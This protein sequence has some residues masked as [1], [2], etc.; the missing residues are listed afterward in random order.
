MSQTK[1]HSMYEWDKFEIIILRFVSRSC[2]CIFYFLLLSE[3]SSKE[4]L[5]PQQSN[6]RFTTTGWVRTVIQSPWKQHENEEWI[7]C[8]SL[9]CQRLFGV[10]KLC[11]KS[12]RKNWDWNCHCRPIECAQLHPVRSPLWFTRLLHMWM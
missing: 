12:G 3:Y 6:Q 11:Q 9:H 2:Q 10:A 5:N 1:E 7:Y 4:Q 8:N